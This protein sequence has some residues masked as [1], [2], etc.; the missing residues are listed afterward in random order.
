MG[1]DPLAFLT[2]G[3][4][5]SFWGATLCH[6]SGRDQFD[7]PLVRWSGAGGEALFK[8]ILNVPLWGGEAGL[9]VLDLLDQSGQLR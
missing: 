8:P 2:P 1:N 3:G 7:F 4:E 5:A 6:A 9:F